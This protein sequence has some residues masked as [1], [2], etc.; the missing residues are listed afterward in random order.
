M[1]RSLSSG[2]LGALCAGF[3]TTTPSPGAV[4]G[5]VLPIWQAERPAWLADEIAMSLT[6]VDWGTAVRPIEDLSREWLAGANFAV[7]RRV[8]EETGGFHPWLDRAGT[9]L[10]SSGDVF[11]QRTL[12]RR[13]YQCVYYPAMA[14][15]HLVPASRLTQRWFARRY[16]WQGVSDAVMEIID[17]LPSLPAR[18]C[19]ASWRAGRLIGSPR[20]RALLMPAGR[21]SEVTRRCLALLDLGYVAG[22]LGAG[23]R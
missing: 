18:A 2:W 19:R 3:E 1:M 12:M 8:L 20:M 14:V 9:N 10:L 16:F 15:R 23:G 6:I 7:P 11:L 4:G 13:G 21:P 17:D 5:R 22:L